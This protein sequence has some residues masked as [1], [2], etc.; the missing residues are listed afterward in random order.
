MQMYIKGVSTR[1]VKELQRNYVEQV[2]SKSHIFESLLKN[3]MKRY[4]PAK[5]PVPLPAYSP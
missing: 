4:L 3:W 2:F 1:K 5:M